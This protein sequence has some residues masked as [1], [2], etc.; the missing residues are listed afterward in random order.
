MGVFRRH[1]IQNDLILRRQNLIGDFK[2]KSPQSN[3]RKIIDFK[4]KTIS[5]ITRDPLDVPSAEESRRLSQ[6]EGYRTVPLSGTFTVKS[7]GVFRPQISK[8]GT[9]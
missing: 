8:R 1:K 4:V 7:W 3:Q 6:S 5:P 2:V 9:F